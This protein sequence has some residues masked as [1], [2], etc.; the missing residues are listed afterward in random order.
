[1]KFYHY[2]KREAMLKKR[3]GGGTHNKFL[4]SFNILILSFSHTE[5][6]AQRSLVIIGTAIIR[7]FRQVIKTIIMIQSSILM[8]IFH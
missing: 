2:T 7:V 5:R 8:P 6:G 4:G 3:G 1:M